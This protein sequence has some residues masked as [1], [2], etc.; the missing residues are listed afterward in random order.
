VAGGRPR[1]WRYGLATA[2][3]ARH[4][5]GVTAVPE[6]IADAVAGLASKNL[7]FRVYRLG[8]QEGRVAIRVS[9]ADVDR[10]I[11]HFDRHPVE[12]RDGT[13]VPVD[14]GALAG[15]CWAVS[16]E[17]GSVWAPDH[18]PP[19]ALVG[20]EV[21]EAAHRAAQMGWFVRAY[22]PEAVLTASYRRNR[23]NL[24]YSSTGRVTRADIG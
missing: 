7:P 23:M 16:P 13:V 8:S 6:S 4:C 11:A 9:A 1:D 14:V 21:R 22:E 18:P 15:D 3:I 2:G 24:C 17:T 20:V 12:L 10:V 5:R 19:H